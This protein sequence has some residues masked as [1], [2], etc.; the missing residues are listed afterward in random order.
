MQ[1]IYLTRFRALQTESA[2]IREHG[3]VQEALLIIRVSIDCAINFWCRVEWN[4]NCN[5][6]IYTFDFILVTKIEMEIQLVIMMQSFIFII[7]SRNLYIIPCFSL[8]SLK[9]WVLLYH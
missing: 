7:K 6:Y 4:I 3:I 1:M 2:L 5:I 9:F 8:S